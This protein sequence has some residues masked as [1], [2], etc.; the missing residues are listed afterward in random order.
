VSPKDYEP[1]ECPSLTKILTEE[2][3]EALDA[4]IL[5]T[6]DSGSFQGGNNK[7]T[8]ALKMLR[9]MPEY[10][11]FNWRGEPYEEIR[12]RRKTQ[13]FKDLL[14]KALNEKPK[15]RG[16]FIVKTPDGY[17]G[18]VRGRRIRR[19]S[20]YFHKENAKVFHY[21]DDIEEL[22]SGFTSGPYWVIEEI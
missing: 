6:Y 17:I 8:R 18:K 2:G 11:R 1:W 14:K 10:E 21:R 16:K 12:A 13:E 22:R 19:I 3:R 15:G 7:W 5:R 4:E 20:I 9:K